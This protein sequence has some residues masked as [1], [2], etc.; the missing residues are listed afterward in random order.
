MRLL[1]GLSVSV[2]CAFPGK[3]QEL[4]RL[5]HEAAKQHQEREG[6]QRDAGA[7]RQTMS[8]AKQIISEALGQAG[9]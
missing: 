1:G 3:L 2:L 4:E 6:K 9:D 7:Y 8:D 5:T